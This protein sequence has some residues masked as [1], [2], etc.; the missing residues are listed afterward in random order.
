MRLSFSV[1]NPQNKRIRVDM[2]LSTL[3]NEYSRSHIQKMIDEWNITIN[4]D[5]IKKNTKISHRD[6][7][8]ID[9]KIEK[10]DIL[11]QN[12]PLDIIYQDENIAVIN[13]DS[14]IASHPTP[15]TDGKRDTL[16]NALLYHIKNLW[17]INWVER[18]GIVHRLDKDTSGI[19]MIAK[20]DEMM[21][22]LSQIIK[23]RW[24]DKYYIAIVY[25][26]IK[27]KNLKIES[28]IGRDANSRV[29]MT[30]KDPIN[31][32][33]SISYI[34]VLDYIDDKYTLIKVKIITGRTHQIRVHLSSIWYPIIWDSVYWNKKIN[35]EVFE[36]YGL[37]RQALHA[38]SLWFELYG[39]YRE[40]YAIV[41]PDIAK[42]INWNI[43][44]HTKITL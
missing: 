33:I 19:M 42:M 31:P 18:P 1:Y 35:S 17:S 22:Y 20:N 21:K 26:I 30:T 15:W 37:S 10:L 29:K 36:K 23:D 41:K 2:Y 8:S 13:K 6:E 43:N 39:E 11:P 14:G 32:K 5:I 25:G 34:K 7:I 16:V 3:L 4:W 27:D 40:F 38:I 24:V 9:I 28:Y 44:L 12:I